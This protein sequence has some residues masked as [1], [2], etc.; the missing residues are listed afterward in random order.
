MYNRFSGQRSRYC[1]TARPSTNFLPIVTNKNE[2]GEDLDDQVVPDGG[3]DIELLSNRR[4]IQLFMSGKLVLPPD[5]TKEWTFGVEDLKNLGEIGHGRF[6]TVCKMVHEQTNYVMAVKRVRLISNQFD[7]C[8]DQR[9][10]KQLEKEVKMIQEASACQEVV[11]F[12]GV[13][14]HEGD[15]LICMEFM[16]ISLE[17]LYK[18][19]HRISKKPFHEDVLGT[20]GVTVL[21]A[22]NNLKQLKHIIHRDV[23]P[24]NILLNLR[25]SIKMC[26]FG[27]SG[28][29]EDS[30]AQTKDVGCR[31]YMAPERLTA[32][33]DG[34]DIRSDVWSM[35]ITLIETARG[36]FPYP[37]FN[38]K[39]L[40]AQIEQVVV[41]DPLFLTPTDGYAFCTSSFINLCLTKEYKD[42]PTFDDLMKTEF[43]QYFSKLNNRVDVVANYVQEMIELSK[44]NSN[45]LLE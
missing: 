39:C 3:K 36:Q 35:G 9:R 44:S 43:F 41:G 21:R 27:I 23:K 11:R 2:K 8:E 6:G 38:E 4:F 1:P 7:D 45:V 19:V 10:M 14:F 28:Y 42:R 26:D 30:M 31:P 13:T 25:G 24:S 20:I 5:Y 22:L 33:I 32:S 16:D 17:K 34:Y 12:Y 37:N 15:C 18:I 40:F 29:L